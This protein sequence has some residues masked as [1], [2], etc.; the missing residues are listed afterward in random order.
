MSDSYRSTGSG[1]SYWDMLLGG[2]GS[3][4]SNR[5]IDRFKMIELDKKTREELGE[6]PEEIDEDQDIE[7]G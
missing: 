6:E 7:T 4:M 1:S 2:G 3:K 5:F